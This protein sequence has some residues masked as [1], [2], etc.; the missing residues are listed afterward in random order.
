MT[1]IAT[2]KIGKDFRVTLPMDVREFL[3]LKEGDELIF[4]SVEDK[5]G[6]VCFR[7]GV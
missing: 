6:R 3:D 7:K 5:R 4:Y 1:V 2:G